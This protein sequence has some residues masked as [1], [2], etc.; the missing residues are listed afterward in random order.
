MEKRSIPLAIIFCFITCGIYGM[1]WTY[2]LTN[3]THEL[4]G[5]QTTASGGMVV[6]Y[7]LITCGIYSFYWLYKITEGINEAKAARNMK[8]NA[9]MPI[10]SIILALFG[11]ALVDLA[12]MQDSIN[13]IIENDGYHVY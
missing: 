8:V 11:L 3:E 5:R 13:D 10:I 6:L 4:L 9:H 1:Y 7:E 12:L 2:K